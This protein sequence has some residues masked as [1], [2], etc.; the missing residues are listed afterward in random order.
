MW[1]MSPIIAIGSIIMFAAF[2][3]NWSGRVK[4]IGMAVGAILIIIGFLSFISS[5]AA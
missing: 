4:K 1:S 3:G 5:C 2:I